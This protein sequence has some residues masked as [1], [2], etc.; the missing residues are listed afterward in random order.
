MTACP[1]PSRKSIY[2]YTHSKI[3][4]LWISFKNQSTC[5][6][7]EKLVY[8]YF[9]WNV[10][11]ILL[12][13]HIISLYIHT[14]VC[15]FTN[16]VV[17]RNIRRILCVSQFDVCAKNVKKNIHTYTNKQE[18]NFRLACGVEVCLFCSPFTGFIL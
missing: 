12:F 7:I 16:E 2:T 14:Y 5:I 17:S 6:I 11:A 18:T 9:P 8:K 1:K 15:N 10:R 4:S 13:E 3:T